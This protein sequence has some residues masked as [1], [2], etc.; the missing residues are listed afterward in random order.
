MAE[1]AAAPVSAEPYGR[2]GLPLEEARDRILAALQPLGR[3]EE[4]P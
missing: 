3:R 4:L 2:E 1:R